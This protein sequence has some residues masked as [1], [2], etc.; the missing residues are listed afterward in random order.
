M[1][2]EDVEKT[3]LTT[4][5]GLYEFPRVGF[6]LRNAAQTF[7][8]FIDEVLL[9]LDFTYLYLDDVL[10]PSKDENEHLTHLKTV[11]ERLQDYGVVVYSVKCV[12]GSRK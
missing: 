1:A 5:F 11:F 3:A 7:Q 6:K 4:S 2:P 12:F 10:I 9:G 8:R